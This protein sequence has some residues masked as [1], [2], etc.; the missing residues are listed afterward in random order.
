M[1]NRTRRVGTLALALASSLAAGCDDRPAP[2]SPPVAATSPPAAATPPPAAA[3]PTTG[4]GAEAP[5]PPVPAAQSA[6]PAKPGPK[7]GDVRYLRTPGVVQLPVGKTADDFERVSKGMEAN[8][9]NVV[10]LMMRAG[11]VWFVNAGT[12]C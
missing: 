1:R 9:D 12:K 7:A 11:D 2:T 10:G 3:T 4:P 5:K 8:D 6:A